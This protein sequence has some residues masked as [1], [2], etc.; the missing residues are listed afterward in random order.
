[1]AAVALQV[2][3]VV[4]ADARG[5]HHA[6]AGQPRAGFGDDDAAHRLAQQFQQRRFGV[7]HVD[8]G[9]DDGALH[10]L[11]GNAEQR[12]LGVGA[13]VVAD[14]EEPAL[15]HL[16][17]P[18]LAAALGARR[19][20]HLARR[21]QVQRQLRRAL[22]A[23]LG[24]DLQALQDHLLQ[25]RR[26][27]F[28]QRTRRHRVH[29]QALAQAAHGLGGTERA[30][31]GGEV[32]EHHAQRED[33]AARVVARELHLLGRH[34]R[35]RAQRQAEFLVQQVGQL[36]VARQAEVHQHRGAVVAEHDVAGLDVQVHQVLAVQ[37]VQ[38]GGDAG[39]DLG[40]LLHRQRRVV[41]ARAQRVAGDALHHDVGLAREVAA[42]HELRHVRA[43]QRRQDHL[44]DLEADDA[45]RVLAALDARHLH[46]QRHRL[47]GVSVTVHARHAPQVRHAA[48]VQAFLE[49]VAV[50]HLARCQ[51]QCWPC[52]LRRHRQRA[53]EVTLHRPAS[54]PGAAAVA[55]RGSWPRRPRCRRARASR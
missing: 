31:P 8:R 47:A 17:R 52:R 37:L 42:R 46:D 10:H 43:V 11:A 15:E 14:G 4:A 55:P 21:L 33:V 30:L 12:A 36:V 26:A 54:R 44:L 7:V 16:Q 2:D 39:A 18:A 35:A 20:R 34:V 19:Q 50:D 22:V 27:V 23:A 32:V 45:G 48:H 13:G 24:L 51:R 6:Q 38:R 49:P 3:E 28:A 41:Q 5:A 40:D 29:V 9:D 1:M 25:P 53:R